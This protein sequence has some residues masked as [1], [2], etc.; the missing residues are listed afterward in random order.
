MGSRTAELESFKREICLPLVA[1][2]M[3]GFEVHEQKSSRNSLFMTSPKHGSIIIRRDINQVWVFCSVHRGDFHGTVTDLVQGLSG[4][5]LGHVRRHLRPYLNRVPTTPLPGLSQARLDLEPTVVDLSAV[6]ERYQ[7]ASELVDG[8]HPY[9]NITRGLSPALLAHPRFVGR[10]RIDTYGNALFPHYG[11]DRQVC[12][13]EIRNRDFKGFAKGGLKGL[14]PSRIT[15]NDMRLVITET[16]I[17]A[18]SHFAVAM[19]DGRH[20]Q[21]RYVSIAGQLSSAQPPLLRRAITNLPQGGQVV[22]ALDHDDGGAM[23]AGV[24]R[25][26]FESAKRPDLRLVE[27]IPPDPGADWNDELLTRLEQ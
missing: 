27:E 1:A 9:L 21:N 22:L 16:A 10:V 12:G 17:D 4:C 6:R 13:L 25:E 26:I 3:Y 5:N 15:E 8:E 18:L 23:L 19:M 11:E 2:E 14:W 20:E 24:L 7:A